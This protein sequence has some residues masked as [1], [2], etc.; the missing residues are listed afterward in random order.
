MALAWYT[1]GLE[2]LCGGMGWGE[3]VGDWVGLVSFAESAQ[4]LLF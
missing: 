1:R 3:G 4:P 2:Q